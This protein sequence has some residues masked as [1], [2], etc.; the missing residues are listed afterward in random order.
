MKNKYKL[1]YKKYKQ[2]YE[3]LRSSL[4]ITKLKPC[5]GDLRKWQLD[6]L[7]YS[8]IWFEKFEQ[9]GLIYFA[10]AG[11]LLGTYRHKGFIPWDDDI[12]VGML[13]PDYEKL[14][15]QLRECGIE[16]STDGMNQQNKYAIVNEYINKYKNQILFIHCP[17]VLQ[18]IQGGTI[19]HCKVLDVFDYDYIKD[20]ITIDELKKYIDTQRKVY[21]GSKTFSEYKNCMYKELEESSV[22]VK[23]SNTIYTALDNDDTFSFP[24]KG[25]YYK[26]D[27]FPLKKIPFENIEI[28]VPNNIEKF[29]LLNYGEDY[30]KIPYEISINNH[31]DYRTNFTK[32]TTLKDLLLDKL[33]YKYKLYNY[34]KN[35]YYKSK[36]KHTKDLITFFKQ[37]S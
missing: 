24:C 22:V 14:I 23:N 5:S 27:I 3:T 7:E 20:G 6:L 4:N 28:Y 37:I 29:F 34:K 11:T 15:N 10:I 26:E 2:E 36:I 32:R 12:D 31:V 21:K 35:D 17:G 30:M 25:V 18:I 19:D 16:I 1:Q 13:R 8:N 9:W 33:L